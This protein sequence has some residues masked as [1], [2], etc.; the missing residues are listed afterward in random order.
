MG[1][2]WSAPPDQGRLGQAGQEEGLQLVG[3][4][5]PPLIGVGVI[6][7]RASWDEGPQGVGWPTPPPG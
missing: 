2:I 5:A 7:G 4:L 6:E 3:G 1:G